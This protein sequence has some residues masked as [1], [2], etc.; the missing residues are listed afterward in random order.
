MAVAG[1]R[2]PEVFTPLARLLLWWT[3]RGV[4]RAANILAHKCLMLAYGEGSHQVGVSH[5]MT[6]RRD[7]ALRPTGLRAGLR[8]FGVRT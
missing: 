5:A 1:W 8:H 3:S 4:P 2:G 6:A 7:V